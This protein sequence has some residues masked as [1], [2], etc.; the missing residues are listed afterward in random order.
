V[1]RTH[2]VGIVGLG[3]ISRVYLAT[4]SGS[5]DV[6]ITAVADL[7]RSRAEEVARSL[8]AARALSVDELVSAD[9][10]DV[11][12]NLTTPGAHADVSLAAIAH[13][14]DV[15]TEKPLAATLEDARRIVAAA[16]EAGV[17]VGCAP[18][19][20]LGT[21]IQTAR[22]VIDAGG[23]GTPISANAVM[24][25]PGHERWHPNPDFYYLPGGGPLLDMGPYYVTA[26][27]QLLGPVVSVV[28]VGS[29]LRAERTI[30][31][32]ARAGATIP[33]EVD[34][35]VTGVLAHASGALSTLTT[36]FDAV[37]S[38]APPIEI[39]GVAASLSVPDPNGFDG[40]V[41]VRSLDG[42]D[43]SRIDPLAGY[44]D[45]AR[46]IGLLDMVRTAD[47]AGSRASGAMGLHVL[48]IMTRMLESAESGVRTP[49]ESTVERP[50]AVPLG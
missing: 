27:V 29:R 7:D 50:A 25:T 22:A 21:G 37:A 49:V 8:P 28:G 23:I 14:K 18:D 20:V 42:S 1:G 36:S 2:R 5:P 40:P 46:G 33:I 48:E 4:L 44:R 30:A 35:H 47:G 34:T 41:E 3:V 12:L 16:S 31:T 10:V 26:L 38:K 15:Y 43:W 32:G 13:G 19:T 6:R 24:A 11:V 45:A 39:H 17:R 9:D